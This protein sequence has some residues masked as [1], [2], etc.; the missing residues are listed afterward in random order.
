MTT[1]L[2]DVLTARIDFPRF[3]ERLACEPE[4]LGLVRLREFSGC[5]PL[6][7][8]DLL[9]VDA[10]GIVTGVEELADGWLALVHFHLALD[11][12]AIPALVEEW[13][14][15]ATAVQVGP[16]DL[17]LEQKVLMRNAFVLTSNRDWLTDVVESSGVVEFIDVLREPGMPIIFDPAGATDRW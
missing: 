6:A 10:G 8:G 16:P 5:L 12:D 13:A 7:P 1:T 9:A 15:S 14:D 2:R 3:E 17:P 11:P 4:A